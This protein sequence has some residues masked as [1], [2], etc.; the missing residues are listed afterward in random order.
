MT[1]TTS[2]WAFVWSIMNAGYHTELAAGGFPVP[3]MMEAAI[4]QRAASIPPHRGIAI[5]VIY[6]SP[7]TMLWQIQLIARLISEGLPID[8]LTIGAGVPSPDAATEFVETLGIKYISFKPGSVSAIEAVIAIAQRFSDFPIM[9]QWTGGRA[10]GHHSYEVQFD[11]MLVICSHIW[12]CANIIL[13]V[14]GRLRDA[15]G[16]LA[17]FTSE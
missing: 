7:Q 9:L 5:H 11:P 16:A 6:A 17:F 13:V 4:R 3:E 2:S 14:G 1:P 15:Q 8:G 12:K 10:G